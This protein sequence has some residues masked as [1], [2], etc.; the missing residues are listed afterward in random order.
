MKRLFMEMTR[1]PISLV[2]TAITTASAVLILTLFAVELAGFQGGPYIGILA[3]LI[4][5]AVFV[6]GLILI[7]IGIRR[8]RRRQQAT[9]E[10]ASF[11]V[12]D[13]NRAKVR[14]VTLALVVLTLINLVILSAA[15]YKGVETLESTEFC[16]EACHSVMTPEYTAYQR[17][18]HAQVACVECHIGPGAEWF[19]KAKLNGAW[20]VVSV[21]F[22]LYE[23]PIPTPVH[24]MRPAR[25]TCGNCHW[26]GNDI[27]DRLK[28]LTKYQEDEANTRVQTVLNLHVG[29]GASGRSSGIHWHADPEVEIRY[30]SDEKRETIYDVE[31]RL[32]DGTVKRY[33]PPDPEA[34]ATAEAEGEL[35]WRR[36]DCADCHN[37]P[38][39]TYRPADW[40]LNLA[41]SQGRIDTTLPFVRREGMRLLTADYDSQ[42]AAASSMPAELES[43]YRDNHPEILA[44]NTEAIEQA[45]AELA[46]IYSWNVFPTMNIT[47]GSYPNHLGHEASPG[48]FRCHDEEHATEE[49]DTISMDC[50]ACHGMPAI[51]EEEPEILQLMEM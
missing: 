10:S 39:H 35:Q 24:N 44:A 11:P 22:D 5:P 18:P 16:G 27:G 8:E 48:C 34:L 7:P 45:G 17:S 50:Y 15:T 25:E 47:W 40:E 20:Q 6:F 37:R 4:L 12:L 46:R 38:S 26:S 19:L 33:L 21:N 51:E 30:R 31:M 43:F 28:V 29:S 2:G 14:N 41:L 23:R 1:N 3:F 9:G 32:P 13:F 42:E 49:G 36:M